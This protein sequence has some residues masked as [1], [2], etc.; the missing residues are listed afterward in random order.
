MPF[1]P[2]H[3]DKLRAWRT[4]PG[5][6]LTIAKE[7]GELMKQAK[8]QSRGLGDAADAWEKVVPPAIGASCEL[9]HIKRGVLTVVPPN[10][11]VRFTLDAWLR[12]GGEKALVQASRS[13]TKIRLG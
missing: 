8:A 2:H 7:M 10:A 9:K 11:S 13:V 6:D 5:K 12:N 3:L 4:A 1:N